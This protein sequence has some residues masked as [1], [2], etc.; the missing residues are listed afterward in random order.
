[1]ARTEWF[2]VHLSWKD[3]TR[4]F[5]RRKVL[6]PESPEIMRASPAGQP[7]AAVPTCVWVRPRLAPQ[8]TV[9]NPSTSSG[10]ALVRLC[11]IGS[12]AHC[13][14]RFFRLQPR[15]EVAQKRG[16]VG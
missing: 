6:C 3:A 2:I 11:E 14:R 9:A 10:Q 8:R 15:G 13:Y 16:F 4:L 7:R 5:L 1:M 12:G